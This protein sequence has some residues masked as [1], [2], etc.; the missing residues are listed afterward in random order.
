MK[1]SLLFLCS[2]LFLVSCNEDSKIQ[3]K[4]TEKLS[5]NSELQHIYDED[6]S[7]RKTANIDWS[8]V[9]KRDSIREARIYEMLE[10]NLVKT[11]KDY[12][13]V[14][15]IFQHGSD[16]TASRM[17]VEM[18]RKAV[19]LDSTQSKWL[20]AAAIDRDLMRRDKPQVYGTQYRRDGKGTPWYLYEIDTTVIS[21]AERIE[22]K[23]ETLAQQSEKERRMNMA[24]LGDL[25]N[26]GKTIDEII[27][28][29]KKEVD[30]ST[31][32]YDVSE[33]ALTSLG[34]RQMGAKKVENA[35]KIFILNTEL[36]PEGFNTWDSLGEFYMNTGETEKAIA[37]YQKSFD[38]NPTNT[39]AKEMIAK[40]KE[41]GDVAP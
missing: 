37:N 24:K 39:H 38:L 5:N 20:L 3:E 16:T 9:S 28:L 15:M 18:M 1:K 10:T 22:Y 32:L 14:A 30:N 29:V 41:E 31:A 4:F 33:N 34:Y 17:A 35:R 8:V 2:I 21:D 6:Q 12:H 26:E 27:L 13:N 25:L 40:M 36:Y 7:D 23:V 19:E 11:G